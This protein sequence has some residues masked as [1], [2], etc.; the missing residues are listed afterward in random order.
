[1]NGQERKV[2]MKITIPKE[3]ADIRK[4]IRGKL[5]RQI[6][7]CA[8]WTAIV[9]AFMIVYAYNYF[10]GALSVGAAYVFWIGVSL[11][12]FLKY[13]FWRW[14]AD[15]SYEG[16]VVS[17]RQTTAVT[18]KGLLSGLGMTL[19]RKYTQNIQ[20]RLP[21]GEEKTTEISWWDGEHVPYYYE[22][23]YIRYYRGTKFPMVISAEPGAHRYCVM[24]GTS[25][26]PEE[27]VCMICGK[28]L[29]D[30]TK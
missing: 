15:R 18:K 23:D 11:I 4:A 26:H 13:K 8:V 21:N 2:I 25:N 29:I 16:T 17:C 1:M 24:C 5:I 30:H 3:N 12:P 7:I 14:F 28:S 10:I 22:G 19:T 27:T 20:I 6:V 9:S